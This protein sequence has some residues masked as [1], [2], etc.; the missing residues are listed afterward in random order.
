MGDEEADASERW[1]NGSG[2]CR[3]LPKNLKRLMVCIFVDVKE[4]K[5]VE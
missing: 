5:T 4:F 3:L 2:G 1:R